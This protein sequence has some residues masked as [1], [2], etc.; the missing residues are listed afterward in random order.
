[1]RSWSFPQWAL[2]TTIVLDAP[3]F[4]EIMRL[5]NAKTIRAAVDLALRDFVARHRER[6]ILELVGQ[7][8]IT[9]D[10][11]VRAVRLAITRDPG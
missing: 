2:R 7:D 3:P 5:S 4:G 8:L 6:E 9:P 1:M 11:D 10:D